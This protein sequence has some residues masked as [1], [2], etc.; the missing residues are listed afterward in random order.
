MLLHRRYQTHV[1]VRHLVG[2]RRPAVCSSAAVLTGFAAIV[3]TGNHVQAVAHGQF[4][5]VIALESTRGRG[6][7]VAV[8]VA[9][10]SLTVW[11]GKIA[12]AY[13]TVRAGL[14]AVDVLHGRACPHVVVP[15]D[16]A[17]IPI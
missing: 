10:A 1:P 14:L 15:N 8:A 6:V 12:S 16:L 9:V 7:A 13:T 4:Q 5:V 3:P 17:H 2:P 11:P